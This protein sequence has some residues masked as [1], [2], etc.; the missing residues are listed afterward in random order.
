MLFASVAPNL[1]GTVLL[2]NGQDSGHVVVFGIIA[3][4][5]FAFGRAKGISNFYNYTQAALIGVICG[6]GIEAIQYPLDDRD[7][8]LGDIGR[9]S[10]GVAIGLLVVGGLASFRTATRRSWSWRVP[11]LVTA[12]GLFLFGVSP[13]IECVIAMRTRDLAMPIVMSTDH[14]W[15]KRYLST[16]KADW[17][18]EEAPP[19]WPSDND[20][21]IC[22]VA[23]YP[24]QAFPSIHL[25]EPTSDWSSG[26][27][28]TFE[29]YSPMAETVKLELRINDEQHDKNGDDYYDRFNRVL[30]IPPGHNAISIPISEIRAAP[31]TREMNMSEICG[32]FLFLPRPTEETHLLFD[33]MRLETR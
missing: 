32:L 5:A 7:A 12:G 24:T 13:V 8:S 14:F 16:N 4:V 30:E 23:F 28:F 18:L 2:D 11:L 9:D 6:V 17:W 22:H 21:Q 15:W 19:D 1:G 26:Q 29:V 20:G 25:R 31:K 10:L 33:N 3:I 27:T